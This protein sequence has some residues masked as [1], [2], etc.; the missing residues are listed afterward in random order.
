MTTIKHHRLY[1]SESPKYC[2]TQMGKQQT[3]FKWVKKYVNLIN[4]ITIVLGYNSEQNKYSWV[5]SDVS[6]QLNKQV[7]EEKRQLFLTEEFQLIN[8]E[9]VRATAKHYSNNGIRQELPMLLKLI[10]NVWGKPGYLCSLK[11]F[12][13][14]IDINYKGKNSNFTG[15]KFSNITLTRWIRFTSLVIRW[16]NITHPCYDASKGRITSVV[17]WPK[18]QKTTDKL[19]LKNIL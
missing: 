14:N 12:P 15:E 8:V 4:K 17:F 10:G 7:N 18:M 9:A 19:K 6:K 16:I 3:L 11:A 1:I 5:H 13:P 2:L